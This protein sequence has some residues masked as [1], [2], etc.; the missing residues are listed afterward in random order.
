MLTFIFDSRQV[1]TAYRR[2]CGNDD[3]QNQPD[4]VLCDSC[5][6][7]F[8]LVARSDAWMD[9]SRA[10]HAVISGL[11]SHWR[12]LPSRPR[13]CHGHDSSK[14]SECTQ[15]LPAHGMEMSAGPWVM[16]TDRGNNGAL[17]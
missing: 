10:L 17:T 3:W 2:V 6:W 11:P 4:T 5:L 16:V 7:L 13:Q 12:H 9:H 1:C 14:R 15:H 8:G